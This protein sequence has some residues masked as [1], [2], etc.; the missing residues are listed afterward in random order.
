MCEERPPLFNTLHMR[1]ANEP[2]ATAPQLS[3]GRLAVTMEMRA[4]VLGRYYAPFPPLHPPQ[5]SVMPSALQRRPTSRLHVA[6]GD[7]IYRVPGS[8]DDAHAFIHIN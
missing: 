3:A 5:Q 6:E 1:R 7:G 2:A 4:D 8:D